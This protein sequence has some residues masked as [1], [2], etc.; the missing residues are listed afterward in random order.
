MRTPRRRFRAPRGLPD[1]PVVPDLDR[2]AIPDVLRTR[3]P[4]PPAPVGV[5]SITRA[6]YDRL[7]P[8]DVAEIESRLTGDQRA[9]WA[10]ADEATRRHVALLYAAWY[11]VEGALEHTGLT[12]AMPPEDVH[13]MARGPQAA[14]GDPYLADVVV[15]AAARAGLTLAP[16]ATVLDFGCSSGRVLRAIAAARP[17][18]ECLGCDPNER[19]IAWASEHLPFGRFFA[20]PFD[21]PL[22]L[23]DGSVDL[24]YAIS[25]W[26]HFGA[27]AAIAW[28]GEMRRIVRPGGALVLTVHGL[29]TLGAGLEHG[30]VPRPEASDVVRSLL[31]TGHHFIDVFGEE[32]DWGVKDPQWG[33]A[34]LSMEW[35]ARNATPDWAIALLEVGG[36]T[37]NQDV[38]VL[39][40]RP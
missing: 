40:R 12:A 28:L 26:S 27:R 23:A 15:D 38:V 11:E 6:L 5:G 39:E 22:E 14:G 17:D 1:Y 35:L 19:A 36:L 4:A 21:P 30:W 20:S 29:Q 16:G 3:P 32:G 2:P 37:G 34:Y 9:T 8:E 33:N 18:L 13:A 7:T 25:I 24:A 10:A 31:A